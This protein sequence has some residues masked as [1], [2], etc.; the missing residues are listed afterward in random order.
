MPK[1]LDRQNFYMIYSDI[2]EN[3]LSIL[4]WSKQNL[5]ALNSIYL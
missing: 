5:T 3:H 2:L 1:K 4:L